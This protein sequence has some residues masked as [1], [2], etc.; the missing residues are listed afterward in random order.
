MTLESFQ[1]HVFVIQDDHGR[2]ELKLEEVTYS[3]GRDP[4]CDIRLASQFVSRRHA[5][6]LQLP[7]ED[8]TRY[9]RIVDGTLRGSPSANGLLINGRKVST[10]DLR[11][12]DEVIFG[13]QVRATYYLLEGDAA[14]PGGFLN[15]LNTLVGSAGEE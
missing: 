1:T 10:H 7:N 4:K 8:G 11:N 6:L 3:I 9:C 15:E 12:G 13:P 2:R 5:T 14:L